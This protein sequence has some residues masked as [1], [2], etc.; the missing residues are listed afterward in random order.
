MKRGIIFFLFFLV[1]SCKKE[2]AIAEDQN[3]FIYLSQINLYAE[4]LHIFYKLSTDDK[5]NLARKLA[6]SREFE[7]RARKEKL[8][9]EK[10]FLFYQEH[11]LFKEAFY[12][13]IVTNF[14]KNELKK[15]ILFLESRSLILTN[16]HQDLI[17]KKIMSYYEKLQRGEIAFEKLMEQE[18]QETEFKNLP[19]SLFPLSIREKLMLCTENKILKPFVVEKTAFLT[20][21]K[22]F[23]YVPVEKAR[24]ILFL[25]SLDKENLLIQAE[26]QRLKQEFLR[27]YR[28]EKAL[29]P[30]WQKEEVLFLS[31]NFVFTKKDF[32]DFLYRNSI[33]TKNYEKLNQFF[34]QACHE[35][36]V[37]QENEVKIN[38]AFF[39]FFTQEF[40]AKLY[41]QKVLVLGK[42]DTIEV[43][44]K[45]KDEILQEINFHFIVEN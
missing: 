8:D 13:T 5:R 15:G 39:Q 25:H 40:L 20:E 14:L 31:G 4:F 44:K 11:V 17:L 27:K 37:I 1:L 3:G 32:L 12:H 41:E 38:P 16:S 9:N 35:K 21:C 43:R 26:T 6:L 42:S 28:C 2:I 29:S 34:A 22:K 7:K 10:E 23:S 36:R 33:E 19:L 24:D 45:L 18:N 30:Q